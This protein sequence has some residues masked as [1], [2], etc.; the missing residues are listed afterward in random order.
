MKDRWSIDGVNSPI[1]IKNGKH[2]EDTPDN[3]D[4][5]YQEYGDNYDP[6]KATPEPEYYTPSAD[7]AQDCKEIPK[8][9][10][11]ASREF[12]NENP[13]TQQEQKSSPEIVE[14]T[15]RKNSLEKQAVKK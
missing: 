1:Q 11:G 15:T 6:N 10:P 14:E 2:N 3:R 13:S 12:D 8:M 4:Q 5:E 9:I 7:F